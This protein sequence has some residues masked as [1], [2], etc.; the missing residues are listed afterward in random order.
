MAGAGF[1]LVQ[2]FDGKPKFLGL[3]GLEKWQLKS[4]GKYDI[5]KGTID[6][7]ETV[8]D[9]A[10]RECYEETGII[11]D[12]KE[13]ISGPMTS[14]F[15]TIWLASTSQNPRIMSNPITGKFEHLGY[16]WLYPKDLW[17]NCFDFL[18]EFVEWGTDEL[19]NKKGYI[20]E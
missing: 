6:V 3:V 19:K 4:S 1:I 20:N 12:K 9:A 10:V 7:N 13:I 18:C 11:V 17:L 8:W 2:I 14:G 16:E 15:L 5:P